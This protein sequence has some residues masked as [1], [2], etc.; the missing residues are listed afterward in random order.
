MTLLNAD[1]VLD[2]TGMLCPVPVV[3]TAK[4]IREIAVGQVLRM[5]ATDPGAVPDMQAWSRQTGHELIDSH[6]EGDTFIFHFRRK[7]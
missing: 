2:C 5:V 6:T 4:A 3:K 1:K 7:K